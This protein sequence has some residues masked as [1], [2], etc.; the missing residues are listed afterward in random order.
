MTIN[1]ILLEL[2]SHYPKETRPEVLRLWAKLTGEIGTQQA[3]IEKLQSGVEVGARGIDAARI[4]SEELRKLPAHKQVDVLVIQVNQ[5]R[6]ALAFAKSVI[7]SGESWS[8]T[9]EEEI[10]SLLK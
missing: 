5:M 8:D 1:D 7:K 6:N 4:L 9:C 10:G 3:E 2:S